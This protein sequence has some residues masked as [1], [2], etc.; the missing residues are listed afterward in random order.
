MYILLISL[1]LGLVA[2]MLFLNF[3]FRWKVIKLYHYLTEHR[4]E[5]AAEHIFSPR[6]LREEIIPRYPES[7]RQILTFVRYIRFSV[8]MAS[9]LIVL[10]TAFGFIL[11]YY[12]RNGS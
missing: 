7:E 11:M 10:I 6:K 5:F 12:S 1:V 4:I 2:A 3:Y 9:I 8:K